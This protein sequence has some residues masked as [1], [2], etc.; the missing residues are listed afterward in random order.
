MHRLR[1]DWKGLIS[2]LNA[3]SNV[4]ACWRA[5]DDT[6]TKCR[7]R[8]DSTGLPGVLSPDFCRVT[9]KPEVFPY[10]GYGMMLAEIGL[11]PGAEVD[12]SSLESVDSYEVQPDRVVFYVWPSAGGAKFD[13]RFRLRYRCDALTGS[14]LLYDYYN[15][16]NRAVVAP[17][18]FVVH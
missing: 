12:R 14:S 18:R 3:G 4:K 5:A 8:A 16:E 1:A 6:T 9:G 7:L 15:A 10:K 17:T 2:L 13:F 11:P